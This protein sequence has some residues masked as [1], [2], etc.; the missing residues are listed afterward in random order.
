MLDVQ[1]LSGKELEAYHIGFILGPCFNAAG[2]ID[3]V[4]RAFELLEETNKEKALQMAR[5]LKD[6]NDTRKQMT[7]EAAKRAF[8]ILQQSGK[9]DEPV[10]IV[11]L[12]DCHE[13][14]VGIVAGRIKE[15]YHHPVI[16]FCPVGDGLV[17]GSGRSIESYHM[18]EKLMACKDLMV[19]FGGHKMAAGMTLHEKDLPELERRLNAEAGLTQADFV[20]ELWIDVAMPVQ[21]ISIPLIEELQTLEPFGVGNPK[22][23]F[24]EQHFHILEAVRRGK[25][26]N[27]LSMKVAN[28]KGYVIKAV[29]FGDID[30]F[31]GFVCEIWGDGELQKMYQ[32]Q[33]NEIDMG[34]AYYPSINEYGGNRTLQIVVTDYCVVEKNR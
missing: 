24:A 32:N 19:R 20:P 2:R 12:P 10:H 26:R 21:Y 29:Y 16:V 1:E 9:E 30:A 17:K 4:T 23:V 3:T 14:L 5:E 33:P 8:D 13:S 28:E 34:F 25:N 31:E 27:V 22:P 18:F 6:I 15:E 11:L 7:E